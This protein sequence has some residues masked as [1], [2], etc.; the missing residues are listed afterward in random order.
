MERIGPNF[1]IDYDIE[2]ADVG[3][4]GHPVLEVTVTNTGDRAGID[5][6]QVY[7]SPPVTVDGDETFRL[8]G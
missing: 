4:V 7:V 6:P 3:E 5:T 8:A 1:S 2:R